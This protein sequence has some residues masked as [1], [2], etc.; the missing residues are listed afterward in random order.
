MEIVI[1][2]IE[3]D[4]IVD[5]TLTKL[6]YIINKTKVEYYLISGNNKL[7]GEINFFENINDMT[8][9]EIK[10]KILKDINI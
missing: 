9:N 1:R 5:N 3:N 10:E 8:I 7:K 6:D 4:L 2:S